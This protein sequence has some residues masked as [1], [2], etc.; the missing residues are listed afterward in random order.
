MRELLCL[1]LLC[2]VP[3]AARANLLSN[4]G[5]EAGVT[6]WQNVSAADLTTSDPHGGAYALRI[7]DAWEATQGWLPVT[8]G[9]TY[10]ATVWF[11]WNAF[12]GNDWG[13]D[14]F[15]VLNDDWTTAASANL[16]HTQCASGVWSK[17]AL[18]FTATRPS[19]QASFGVFGPQTLIDLFFDDATL[20]ERTTN[21]PPRIAP[22]A[23]VTNGTVPLRVQFHANAADD[24]GAIQY[25]SWDF[26]D[27]ARAIS[28][29]LLHTYIQ[30]GMHPVTLTVWDNDGATIT[31][32]LTILATDAAAPFLYMASP[33]VLTTSAATITLQGFATS[34][35][36][37]I[38]ALMWDNLNTH[39][40]GVIP[41][42]G[43][44]TQQWQVSAVPLKPGDNLLLLT[45][46]DARGLIDTARVRIHRTAGPPQITN[47]RSNTA[48]LGTFQ[49]FE[50]T[51]AVQTVADS[52]FFRF[53]PAPPPGITP[54]T[55]ISVDGLVL[56]PSGRTL[57]HPAFFMTDV[58][59]TNDYYLETTNQHWCLRFT[60]QEPGTHQVRLCAQDARGSVTQL[61]ATLTVTATTAR[62]FVRVSTS[63]WRYFAFSNGA[64]FWPTGPVFDDYASNA[65]VGLNF[66]RPWM[67]GRGAYSANWARWISTAE[68]HGNEGFAARL[69]LRRQCYG[70][71]VSQEIFYPQGY[72]IW[73]GFLDDQF[74][75]RLQPGVRYR[76]KIRLR[77]EDI[78]GPFA[79]GFPWGFV[80]KTSAWP[81]S[82]MTNFWSAMR[83]QPAL[84]P[85][86]IGSRGWHTLITNFIAEANALDLTYL[87]L[88]LDN[89]TNGAVYIDELSLR[90][91]LVDDTPGA[92][93]IRNPR[94]DWHA[95]VEQRPCAFFDEQIEQG[96]RY[97]VFHKYV[98][99][100]KNDWI[101][102]HLVNVGIFTDTGQ[103]YY[104]AR[105]TKASWLQEQWWRYLCARWGYSPAVHSW[106]LCNEGPPNDPA[107]WRRA[108]EFG[109][110]MR[111]NDAHPHLKTTSFWA[112]WQSA[113]W[114]NTSAYPDV[115]YADLHHYAGA[116]ELQYDM[117]AWHLS[118]S[119]SCFADAV[120]KP[121][122]RAETGIDA[123]PAFNFLSYSNNPGVWYH[124]LLWAQLGYGG[125]SDPA[126]WFGEHCARID[127]GA[128]ARPFAQFIQ[129][130]PL[131][132][133]GY[134]DIAAVCSNPLVR[135]IGQKNMTRGLAHC[136]IQNSRHTWRNVM[137]VAAPQPI[138]P[139]AAE[140]VVRLHPF[141]QYL[142]QWWSTVTGTVT[143]TETRTTT[144]QGDLV[145]NVVDL[146]DDLAVTVEP[147]P[148]PM[149]MLTMA[150]A[151]GL[152]ILLIRRP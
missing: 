65:V 21:L 56:T 61:V 95:Y 46:T 140:I 9:H 88:Y 30:R 100:D 118:D 54:A 49:K 60:P 116:S 103:G 91:V 90:P 38:T 74:R 125:M 73:M 59:A 77:C 28:A 37:A 145:L 136:W 27:G 15:A 130:L 41:L 82:D 47:V 50:A 144:A 107:H 129:R 14:T 142:L 12:S 62:G 43:N 18:T 10:L 66:T 8:T 97:G 104:Q 6:P 133:G 135:V 51:F 39:D 102:N 128:V 79:P 52:T 86:V 134:A 44:Q 108:Q 101:P 96:A 110:C 75:A 1:L 84:L 89:V 16:L 138:T 147:V 117:A 36:S 92:E 40:A 124:N 141:T 114:G 120:G 20:D 24:D 151:G 5:F 85:H 67:G 23:S 71:D 81:E 122:I 19:V 33:G 29:D 78:T 127:R 72:R 99:Q 115:D 139:Q 137:G 17:I 111:L 126:Y 119:T 22:T 58:L 83:A 98:V 3:L 146:R 55:G 42:P 7:T 149:G 25:Y 121:V 31:S 148:E 63:D 93:L 94:A 45:A 35:V 123:Q 11:K 26:G 87:Q 34:A 113:F 105:A 131:Q 76:L 70:S 68:Q 109:A 69:Q 48:V 112:T 13:F 80:I 132:E 32:N 64:L 4:P 152:F 2:C 106:E 53:D 143:A 57:R 150:A